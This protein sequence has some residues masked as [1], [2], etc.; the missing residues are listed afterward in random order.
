[1]ATDIAQDVFMKLWQKKIDFEPNRTKGLLYKMASDQ[2]ISHHRRNKVADQYINSLSLQVNTE[3]PEEALQF[4]EMKNNYEMALAGMSEKK[5]VVFLMNRMEGLTYK[6]IAERLDLSVKA[7]EKRMSQA[8]DELRE[9]L[10][11]K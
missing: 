7:I 8:L 6:E 4:T 10:V 9:K 1:M 5:R 2:F 11:V 3:T